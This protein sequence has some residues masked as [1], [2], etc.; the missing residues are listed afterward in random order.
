MVL[1]DLLS[2]FLHVQPSVVSSVNI[3]EHMRISRLVV[4]AFVTLAG[5][6][7]ALARLRTTC[8]WQ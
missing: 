5:R 8:V 6:F 1:E 2:C 7:G 4:I 3:S